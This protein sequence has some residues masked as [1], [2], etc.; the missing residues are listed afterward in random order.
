MDYSMSVGELTALLDN[1][2]EL[3]KSLRNNDPDMRITAALSITN[4][5]GQQ[6][7]I[8]LTKDTH[9]FLGPAQ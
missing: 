5:D 4:P 7:A 2:T 9:F 8:M 6:F 3:A 1:C